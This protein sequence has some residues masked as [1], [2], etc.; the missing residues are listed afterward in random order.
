M[1]SGLETISPDA[2]ASDALVGL[3]SRSVMGE[4]SECR[5]F[6]CLSVL[7]SI[8]WNKLEQKTIADKSLESLIQKISYVLRAVALQSENPLHTVSEMDSVRFGSK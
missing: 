1:G 2:G 6:E 7:V 4:E 3:V 8:R 5:V